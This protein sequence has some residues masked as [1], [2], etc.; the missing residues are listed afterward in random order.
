MRERI[1]LICFY[2]S[3]TWVMSVIFGVILAQTGIVAFALIQPHTSWSKSQSWPTAAPILR[4]GIPCG[5]E[6]LISNASYT[7]GKKFHLLE[8]QQFTS[9]AVFWALLILLK[10]QNFGLV[11]TFHS[12]VFE[13]NSHYGGQMIFRVNYYFL[14]LVNSS[15]LLKRQ[16][17]K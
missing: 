12:Q 9:H 14:S 8:K 13:P 5:H 7:S 17:P 16:V 15:R 3:Q 4:S 11:A 6:K 10:G 1:N 2:R